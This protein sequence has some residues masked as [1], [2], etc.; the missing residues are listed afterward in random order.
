MTVLLNL[1]GQIKCFLP[2]SFIEIRLFEWVSIWEKV[3]VPIE[4]DFMGY[5]SKGKNV[6]FLSEEPSFYRSDNLGGCI[7]SCVF[8]A[9]IFPQNL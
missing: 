4:Q 6:R 3:R 1:F 8:G 5:N 7:Q 9:V 2:K